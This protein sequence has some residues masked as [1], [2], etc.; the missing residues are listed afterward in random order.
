MAK[1]KA[2]AWRTDELAVLDEFYPTEGLNRCIDALPGRSWHAI[3]VMAHKRGLKSPIVGTAP[4]ANLQGD[5]LEEAI[6]LREQ[7]GWSFA[8]I[9]AHFGVSEASACNSVLIALC[10]RKGYRPAARDEHGRLTGEGVERL[11]LM[12]RKGLK[13]VDIQLRL[14]ISA[15]RIA[16]ERRRYTTDLKARGKAPLPAAGNGDAYSGARW[17]KETVRE[18]ERLLM[19]GLGGPKIADRLGVSKTQVQRV[20]EK[21]VKRLRRKGQCLTGCDIDGRRIRVADHIAA[22]PAA[23]V[24]HLR[25]LILEGVPVARAALMANMGGS[26]AYQIRDQLKAELEADGRTLPP[27]RRLGHAR[28]RA[29]GSRATWLPKGRA[30]LVLYRRMLHEANGDAAVARRKTVR[31]IAERD[32]Q[33]PA[34]A[35]QLDRVR[36]GASITARFIPSKCLPDMTLGGVATGALS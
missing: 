3:Q 32:G 14:G 8:R 20:R 31:A 11:R 4:E 36:R 2:P 6:R 19:E 30:N 12:L 21:L 25:S 5:R 24:A 7:E 13:G 23:D 33:D 15:G 28:A 26:K 1:P 27:I 17:P 10:P 16:L 22:V 34:L 9:G 18:V 29:A 35:E